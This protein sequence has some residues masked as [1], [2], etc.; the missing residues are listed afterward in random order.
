MLGYVKSGLYLTRLKVGSTT[1]QM[2]FFLGLVHGAKA[3]ANI[4]GKKKLTRFDVLTKLEVKY[5]VT[6]DFRVLYECN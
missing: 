1:V 4:S 2:G 5:I 3:W 6:S